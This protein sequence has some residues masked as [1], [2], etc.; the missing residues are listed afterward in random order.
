MP[1]R[2]PS[3]L[4]VYP[5]LSDLGEYRMTFDSTAVT[6]L[7][8]WLSWQVT[9]SDRFLS[10]PGPGKRKNDLLFTTGLRLTLGDGNLGNI[11]PSAIDPQ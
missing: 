10:N 3:G 2:S 8:D 7:N 6:R 11:G 5:N 1:R 4:V 9:L